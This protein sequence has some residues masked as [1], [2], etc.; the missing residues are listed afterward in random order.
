MPKE[1][2]AFLTN[3]NRKPKF[4]TA[5][6]LV[7]FKWPKRRGNGLI[8]TYRALMLAQKLNWILGLKNKGDSYR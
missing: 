7:E 2:V 5:I 4:V 6:Y 1:G 8:E 3:I